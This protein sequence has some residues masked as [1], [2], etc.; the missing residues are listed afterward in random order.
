MNVCGESSDVQGET[1]S[2]WMERLTEILRGYAKED[3]YNL[4]ETGS[5]WQALPDLGF[6]KRIS[7]VK[8]GKGAKRGSQ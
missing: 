1:V 3:I 2:S 8:G 4:D 5:F 7:S 6:G